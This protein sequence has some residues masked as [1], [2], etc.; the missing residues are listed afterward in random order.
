MKK[1]LL[2]ILLPFLIGTASGCLNFKTQTYKFNYDTGVLEVS[3][4]DVR[5]VKGRDDKEDYIDQDWAKLKE[6]LAKTDDYD[7]HVVSV[8]SK[9]IFPKNDLLSGQAVYQVQCP[10]CFPSK[11][12]VL[13]M[14]YS[15]GRWEFM[16]DEIVL[17]LP[18]NIPLVFSNGKLF[19]TEKNTLSVWPAGTTE[20]EFS[21]SSDQVEG[22]S[23]LG[24]YQEEKKGQSE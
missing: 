17:V 1:T 4:D 20:F 23:L 2:A 8:T 5:S 16:N 12:D 15:D 19:K 14:L 7:P 6:F 3:Y 10:K 11:I 13:K 9:T 18:S 22:V 21:I 24:K